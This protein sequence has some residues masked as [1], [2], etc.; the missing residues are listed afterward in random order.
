MTSSK[1]RKTSDFKK[2]VELPFQSKDLF[3]FFGILLFFYIVYLGQKI[4]LPFVF[5]MII[6]TLLSPIVNYL[7][8]KRFN[9]ILAILLVLIV[10]LILM[11][12]LIFFI[13]SQISLLGDTIPLLKEKFNLGVG[14]A[15]NWT[16]NTFNMSSKRV[17]MWIEKFTSDGM[18]NTTNIIG[19]TITTIT[20]VLLTMILLPIYTF[21]IL[22]YKQLLLT[23]ISKIFSNDKH[24]TIADVLNESKSLIQSYLIGL[25]IEAGIVA[26]LNS[27]TLLWIGIDYAVLL[28]IVCA[29][30]N[31]IPYIGGIIAII[32]TMTFALVTKTPLAAILV[33]VAHLTVQLIDNNFLV[34][35]IVGSK[36]KINALVSIIVVL[37]GGELFGVPGMFL[38]IPVT[39]IA[40]VICDRIEKLKPIGFLLGDT[41]P[42]HG[43][44]I[45][46]MKKSSPIKMD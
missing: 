13:L 11:T 30:L 2:S 44:N 5:S 3:I 19:Q 6:A 36:V 33:L 34:P 18:S 21:L 31:I 26:T 46:D 35:K 20:H 10:A 32:L 12:G 7:V 28:G 39:A 9:R 22:L 29:L 4:I 1:Y 15:V 14:E 40:K 41:I 42:P 17:N 25:L 8:K 37:V 45:F 27:V 24:T 38:S 16:S 23:F 43:K